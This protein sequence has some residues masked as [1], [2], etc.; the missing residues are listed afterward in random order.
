MASQKFNLTVRF[1]TQTE[2]GVNEQV[3]VERTQG[4]LN[5]IRSAVM[6]DL[7]DVSRVFHIGY[8][9]GRSVYIPVRAVCKVEFV[10]WPCQRPRVRK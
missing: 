9:G 7:K 10:I 5:L 6:A 1:V 3:Y 2:D 4:D 8:P